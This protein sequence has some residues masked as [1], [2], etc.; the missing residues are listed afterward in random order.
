M[1]ALR[2]TDVEEVSVGCVE[3]AW[4]LWGLEGGGGVMGCF[5]PRN[6]LES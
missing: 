2:V 6:G 5:S 4:G 1:N 3:V